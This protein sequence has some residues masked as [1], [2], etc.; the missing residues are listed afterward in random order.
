VA[1]DNAGNSYV[2]DYYANEEFKLEEGAK[3]PIILP[4]NDIKG[5][6]GV[7][8]DNAGNLYVADKGS[9]RVLKLDAGGN[10][11]SVLPFR[12]GRH[13]EK[14]LCRRAQ[15]AHSKPSPHTR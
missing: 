7:A 14:C 15:N 5:P 8:V 13:Q 11:P 12:R 6:G 3:A 4:L 10:A 2:A 9:H 1:V